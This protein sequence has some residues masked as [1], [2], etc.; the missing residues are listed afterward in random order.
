MPPQLQFQI[1]DITSDK[2]VVITTCR[3]LQLV[4]Y[5]ILNLIEVISKP[6]L[7]YMYIYA[8]KKQKCAKNV[9]SFSTLHQYISYIRVCNFSTFCALLFTQGSMS[10]VLFEHF[11]CRIVSVLFKEALKRCAKSEDIE[12]A[13]LFFLCG[14]LAI[15]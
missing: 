1:V 12:T 15:Y 9:P 3:F 2:L 8:H 5:I 13:H 4:V 6:P 7:T 11:M 14:S 10:T